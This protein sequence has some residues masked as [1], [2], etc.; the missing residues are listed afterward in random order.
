MAETMA[1]A[2]DDA[3]RQCRDMDASIN[4]RLACYAQ[5]VQRLTPK[6]AA[7]VERMV[8]RL[9]RAGAG[10]AAPKPGDPMPPFALPDEEGRIVSLEKLLANGPVAVTFHRGHWCPYCR[11]NVNALVRA[12][13]EIANGGRIVAIMPERQEF[14]VALKTDSQ[15]DFPILTDLD[16]GYAMALNLVIWVG[17]EM[18]KFLAERSRELPRYQGNDAWMLPI[19]ATFV[20]GTD[21]LVKARFVDPDYPQAHGH[22]RHAHRTAPRMIPRKSGSRFS[23]K[24]SSVAR[25]EPNETRG[26]GLA[27]ATAPAFVT[28]KPGYEFF[29]QFAP[30]SIFMMAVATAVRWRPATP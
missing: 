2:L 17:A 25:V 8:D 3:L 22:R 26:R 30:R 7:A 6:F 24:S 1:H 4:E 28:L 29:P 23:D 21:G 19:P 12:Q 5:A 16:N 14:A 15:A 18:E 27:R 11:I 20:V 9:A 10:E 13:G